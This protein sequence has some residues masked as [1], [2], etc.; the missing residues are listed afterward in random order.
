MAR[1]SLAR[2]ALCGADDVPVDHGLAP[3]P[4]LVEHRNPGDLEICLRGAPGILVEGIEM[5][6]GGDM[7]RDGCFACT[8][9]SY[10]HE[11]GRSAPRRGDYNAWLNEYL[12]TGSKIALT[13]MEDAVRPEVIPVQAISGPS[14]E[15]AASQQRKMTYRPAAHPPAERRK[16]QVNAFPIIVALLILS[17]VVPESAGSLMIIIAFGLFCLTFRR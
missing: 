5:C 15:L 14:A 6:A 8:M 17:P 4:R 3:W 16:R 9:K 11:T 12:N 7:P 10:E 13:M 2:C 1:V